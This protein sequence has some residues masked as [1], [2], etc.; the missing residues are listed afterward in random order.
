MNW[1]GE[2]MPQTDAEQSLAQ[3][4]DWGPTEDWSDWDDATDMYRVGATADKNIP[5][6]RP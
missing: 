6:E 3:I 5:R 4:A 2:R 1:A